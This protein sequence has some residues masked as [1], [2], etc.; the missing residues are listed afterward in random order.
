MSFTVSIA[1]MMAYTDR[2]FRYLM[3]L[4]T[5]HTVLYTE[6]VTAQ[7]VIYGDQERLLRYSPEEH[8]VVL[9]LGGNDPDLLARSAKIGES[10][11]YDEINLNVGCPSERVQSGCFGAALMKEADLVARCIQVMRDAVSIPV[12]IK[13]RLGVDDFDSDIFLHDFIGKIHETGCDVFIMHARTAWLKGL[14]PKENRT[15]PPL[16]YERVYQ[17]KK[18]FPDLEIIM[19]GGIETIEDIKMHLQ[20]VDG[21]MSGRTICANPYFLSPVDQLFYAE[22]TAI[23]SRKQ[24]IEEYFLY[25][26]TQRSLG[27]PARAMT[28]HLIG[29]YQGERGART[30]RRKLSEAGNDDALLKKITFCLK[31]EVSHI[32]R[33]M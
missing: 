20:T 1:P 8:P 10:F 11:G 27:V 18:L 29:L 5:R 25:I 4:I 30:W 23:K 16:Q 19:N 21:V 26:E 13:T 9:Q 15:L 24:I 6:M 32:Q 14:S 2:H 17:L 3:R 33:I 12:T 31:K 28:R 7:A 22:K